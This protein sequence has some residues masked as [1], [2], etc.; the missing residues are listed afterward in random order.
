MSIHNE[1][2]SD[3]AFALLA[4]KETNPAELSKLKEVLLTVHKTLRELTVNSRSRAMGKRKERNEK[5]LVAV[6]Q[7]IG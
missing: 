6:D 1:L 5:K 4:G 3:I 2:S 7:S